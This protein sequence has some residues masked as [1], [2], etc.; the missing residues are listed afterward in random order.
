MGRLPGVRKNL[1]GLN[2]A[3]DAKE[4]G[5]MFVSVHATQPNKQGGKMK[6]LVVVATIFVLTGCK[7]SSSLVKE[8]PVADPLYTSKVVSMQ[9][10]GTASVSRVPERIPLPPPP[11][12][13][14]SPSRFEGGTQLANDR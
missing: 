6:R 9:G 1:K 11:P 8:K 7:G 5:A 2:W 13:L 10:T 12:D 14:R 3:V 4:D